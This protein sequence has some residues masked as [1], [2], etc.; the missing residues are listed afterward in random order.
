MSSFGSS[1]YEVL[2]VDSK[3][4]QPVYEYRETHR[5]DLVDNGGTDAEIR[6]T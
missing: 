3:S 4:A 6:P 1:V 2:S 5:N